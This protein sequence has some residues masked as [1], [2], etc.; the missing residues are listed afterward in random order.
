MFPLFH[1]RMTRKAVFLLAC[2]EGLEP[3]TCCLEGRKIDHSR[4]LIA[5]PK[6]HTTYCFKLIILQYAN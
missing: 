5:I 4:A 6:T 3:P 1:Q 2:P